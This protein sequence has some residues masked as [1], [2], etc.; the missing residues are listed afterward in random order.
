MKIIVWLWNPWSEYVNTRHN[1]WFLFLDFLVH[2]W[3]FEA[4]KASKFKALISE[5]SL[6]WEKIILV[7]PM[8][9]MNLSWEAI[10]G[11]VNFY[12]I[13]F[14]KDLIVVFDDMSMEFSKLRFR[15]SWSAGWHNGIKSII[16]CLWNEDFSRIKIW[17]GL[18]T[19]YSVSDWVLS[20][21]K[22]E[23]LDIIKNDI[24]PKTL[25]LLNDYL[26]S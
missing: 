18:D 21:F 14:K 9:F 13:D 6:N 10:S 5:W 2:S 7:K 1:V 22:K 3:N 26:L 25:V 24:F 8:T 16:N 23:E 19:K 4:F 11:I 20:K 15:S 12:K 17:V